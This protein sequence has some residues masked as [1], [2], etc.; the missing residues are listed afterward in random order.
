MAMEVCAQKFYSDF[1]GDGKKVIFRQLNATSINDFFSDLDEFY[2]EKDI[3]QEKLRRRN[4]N[5]DI[6]Q[7]FYEDMNNYYPEVYKLI[8][9]DDVEDISEVL[10]LLNHIST[11]MTQTKTTPF[12]KIVVTT[13]KQPSVPRYRKISGKNF[14]QIDGF[15]LENTQKLFESRELSVDTVERIYGV[16]GGSPLALTICMKSLESY[17][18]S[19][20]YT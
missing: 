1:G 4:A 12:W 7:I 6:L 16:L 15:N 13:Q 9:L 20:C 18:V 2:R 19:Y 14:V 5:W 3:L 17:L 10:R 8:I 11:I